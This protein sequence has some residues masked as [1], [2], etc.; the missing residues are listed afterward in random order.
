MPWGCVST[1][2][3]GAD[4]T[5][6]GSGYQ[7][8]IDIAAEC[9]ENP[10]AASASLNFESNGFSDW[11]LPSQFE[12]DL[13]YSENILDNHQYWASTE[14]NESSSTAYV[15][16]PNGTST[17]WFKA[18]SCFVHP[19]RAF[20]NWTYGCMD[21][22]ACN[23]NN[24]ANLADGS[25]TYPEQGYDCEGNITAEIG[26][27][28]EGGY[29]FYLDETGQHGLVAAMEDVGQFE[30]GCYGT[31]LSGAGGQVI[32]TGYQNTLDIEAGCSEIPIAAGEA[33]AYASDGYDDWYLPSKDEL[34]EIYN[35]IAQGSA[36]GNIGV[37][38]N[39]LY[40]SS[41]EFNING[42]WG[43]NFANNGGA[44]ADGK[45]NTFRVRAIRSF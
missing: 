22:T 3:D 17:Y 16:N 15:K 42:A 26:D 30:W 40:W 34:E 36:E 45:S 7:N 10:I 37:F 33:L 8:S 28:I 43:F 1:S 38:Q 21:E 24:Y 6:I 27:I 25:C 44:S 23:Y 41:S 13:M 2:L 19:I 32:G 14:S 5:F 35:S 20:G 29:L 9:N 39:H 11:F 4:L 18:A 31:D 12:L